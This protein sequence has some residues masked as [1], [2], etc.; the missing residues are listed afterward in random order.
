MD[1][2]E[3]TPRRRVRLPRSLRDLTGRELDDEVRFHLEVR[4][5][6]LDP[7]AVLRSV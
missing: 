1:I 7:A 2:E 5:A 6:Q 3:P 4:A